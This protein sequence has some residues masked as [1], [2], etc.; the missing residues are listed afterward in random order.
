MAS[1]PFA[2]VTYPVPLHLLAFFPRP[3]QIL[4]LQLHPVLYLVSRDLVAFELHEGGAKQ[5]HC[6]ILSFV[7]CP[8]F[9]VVHLIPS[10]HLYLNWIP[11]LKTYYSNGCKYIKSQNDNWDAGEWATHDRCAIVHESAKI[12][13]T[14]PLSRCRTFLSLQF[15]LTFKMRSDN[16]RHV[17][18]IY[19]ILSECLYLE[20]CHMAILQGEYVAARCSS[21]HD[22]ETLLT[23]GSFGAFCASASPHSL[24]WNS[25]YLDTCTCINRTYATCKIA[26]MLNSHWVRQ[27][28]PSLW[29][30]LW[31]CSLAIS[32]WQSKSRDHDQCFKSCIVDYTCTCLELC[33]N[34]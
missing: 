18:S 6:L 3:I 23:S 32:L 22:S 13:T 26:S 24:F 9:V 16:V 27:N 25:G 8:P 11:L 15:D 30:G 21:A 33:N 29:G 12:C 14:R 10:S 1:L 2:I 7:A 34:W 4:Y 19:R 17:D 28:P 20:I 5:P 31:L